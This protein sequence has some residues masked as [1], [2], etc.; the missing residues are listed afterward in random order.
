[1]NYIVTLEEYSAVRRHSEGQPKEMAAK[2]HCNWRHERKSQE[3][4]DSDIG[5][6]IQEEKLKSF[7][8]RLLFLLFVR[9]A[10]CLR[11]RSALDHEDPLEQKKPRFHCLFILCADEKYV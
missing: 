7:I 10:E 4:F 9:A 1:M 6:G 11:N 8:N 2:H 3:M 5:V